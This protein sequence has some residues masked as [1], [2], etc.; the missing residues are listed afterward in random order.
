[1]NNNDHDKN[2]IYDDDNDNDNERWQVIKHSNIYTIN[3]NK[4]KD[5][6]E[7]KIQK[8]CNQ[9]TIGIE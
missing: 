4:K 8:T 5:E 3:D 1:M 7:S 9:E 2:D 6:S